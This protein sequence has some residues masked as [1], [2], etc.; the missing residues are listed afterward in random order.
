VKVR[1]TGMDE[2]EEKRPQ[3]KKKYKKRKNPSASTL[4][5]IRGGAFSQSHLPITHYKWR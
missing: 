3:E 4:R 2:S 5:K 1:V